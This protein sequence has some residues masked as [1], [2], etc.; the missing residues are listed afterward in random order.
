MKPTRSLERAPLVGCS[1]DLLLGGNKPCPYNRQYHFGITSIFRIIDKLKPVFFQVAEPDHQQP[2]QGAQR[3][4]RP[5]FRFTHLSR[6][7]HGR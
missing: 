3:P 2:I 4:D 7:T 6:S 5:S 1:N